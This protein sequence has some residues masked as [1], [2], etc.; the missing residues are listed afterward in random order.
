MFVYPQTRY[1]CHRRY[2]R[3]SRT[4][5][6]FGEI[7]EAQVALA[8]GFRNEELKNHF[9]L[10]DHLISLQTNSRVLGCFVS[11]CLA[12]RV[13]V[14]EELSA[15]MMKGIGGAWQRRSDDHMRELETTGGSD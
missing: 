3:L 10:A 8:K 12:V 9:G 13:L 14:D 7:Y 1:L 6:A 5:E 15:Q 11:G 2:V 4:H